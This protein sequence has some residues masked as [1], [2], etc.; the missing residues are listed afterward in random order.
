MF[1]DPKYHRSGYGLQSINDIF[2]KYPKAKRWWL[3]TPAWNVRTRLFYLKSGFEIIDEKDE[4][5]IFE[6]EG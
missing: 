4:F 6:Y 3:D 1:I 2:K 5:R